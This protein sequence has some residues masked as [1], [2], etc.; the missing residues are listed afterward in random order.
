MQDIYHTVYKYMKFNLSDFATAFLICD[1][2]YLSIRKCIMD[3][4]NV[5]QE[6][7]DYQLLVEA[8]N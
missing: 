5:P 4:F 7:L 2:F 6:L 1:S 3:L 8:F